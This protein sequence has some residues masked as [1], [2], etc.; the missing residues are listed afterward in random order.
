MRKYAYWACL[1][2]FFGFVSVSAPALATVSSIKDKVQ[3]NTLVHQTTDH[4]SDYRYNS[5]YR[6]SYYPRRDYDYSYSRRS[7]Y[8]DNNYRGS[9]YKGYESRS[10]R[11]RRYCPPRYRRY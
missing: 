5:G 3:L 4:Y 1:M 7:Y 10:Y 6:E 11:S 9:S 2:T 8:D